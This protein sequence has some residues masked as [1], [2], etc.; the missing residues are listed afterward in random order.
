[1]A[2]YFYVCICLGKGLCVLG[3]QSIRWDDP[4]VG[5]GCSNKRMSYCNDRNRFITD[6]KECWL[7]IGDSFL[8][9]FLI[10]AGSN[11]NI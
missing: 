1:M 7:R 9:E 4:L 10:L 2:K 3:S 11:Y 8:P 6:S 5:T